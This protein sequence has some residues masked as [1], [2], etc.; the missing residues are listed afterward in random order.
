MD[1]WA[2]DHTFR[3]S[4]EKKFQKNNVESSIEPPTAESFFVRVVGFSI[5]AGSQLTS[6]DIMSIYI[7]YQFCTESVQIFSDSM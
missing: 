3:V 2:K 6:V 7:H 4:K 5:A 1:G